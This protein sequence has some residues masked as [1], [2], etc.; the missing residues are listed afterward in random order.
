MKLRTGYLTAAIAL[1]AAVLAACSSGGASG[2]SAGNCTSSTSGSAAQAPQSGGTLNYLV[3]G[4]LS[5]WDLG[6]DPATGGAAPSIYEDAI[7]G[8]LFR[9]T[10]SGGIEPVLA[11]GYK[12]SGGGTVLTISLQPGVK[13]SDGTPFNAAA[14]AW[15]VKRRPGDAVHGKPR[16]LVAAAGQG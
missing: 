10:S 11:T 4:L 5:E 14:V 7:F 15:N 2:S 3:S 13:F 9:A 16:G 8:Q 1:V 6:L 12:V